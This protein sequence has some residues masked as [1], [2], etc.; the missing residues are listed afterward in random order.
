VRDTEGRYRA[1]SVRCPFTVIE[2]SEP[3]VWMP[4]SPP[5]EAARAAGGQ[6]GRIV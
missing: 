1:R 2:V 4:G 5:W 3:T 6:A